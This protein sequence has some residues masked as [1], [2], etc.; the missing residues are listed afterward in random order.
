MILRPL[1]LQASVLPLGH[2]DL[3]QAKHITDPSRNP[4][5][6]AVQHLPSDAGTNL[7]VVVGHMSSAGKLFGRAPP[8]VLSGQIS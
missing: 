2:C 6:V 1:A 8:L 5:D 4:L 3:Q 7:K